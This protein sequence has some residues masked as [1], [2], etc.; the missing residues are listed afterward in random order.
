MVGDGALT[1][2]ILNRLLHNA[3][4]NNIRSRSNWLWDL[5]SAFNPRQH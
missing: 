5:G 4:L 2:A 1:A 3:N